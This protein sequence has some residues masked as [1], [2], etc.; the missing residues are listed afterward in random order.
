MGGYVALEV[1][2]V[3]P[4]RVVSPALLDTSARADTPEQTAKGRELMHLH[5]ETA[6]LIPGS[7]LVVVEGCGHLSTLEK[8]E[9][10]TA[11][12][13]GWLGTTGRG[14]SRRARRPGAEVR[15]P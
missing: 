4:E 8:P 15:S 5:E 12:M 10:V 2:R 3:A 13:R 9:E 6:S 14:G 1:L 7:G 11:A